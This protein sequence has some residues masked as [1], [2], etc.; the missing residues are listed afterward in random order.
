M[1]GLTA[2]ALIRQMP[3]RGT[4]PILALTA[5]AFE[6]DRTA[7]QQAGL[8]E[9]LAKPIEPAALFGAL[10]RW[11]QPRGEADGSAPAAAESPA[12]PFPTEPP[13]SVPAASDGRDLLS[14]IDGLDAN[15]GLEYLG[16]QMEVYVRVLKLFAERCEGDIAALRAALDAGEFQDARRMAHTI[17]GNAAVLGATELQPLA[18]EL[19][20]LIKDDE[21]L[22]RLLALT[23][24]VAAVYGALAARLRAKLMPSRGPSQ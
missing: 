13:A 5:N 4:V 19:E 9:H 10:L 11:L 22:P 3:G 20:M 14:E 12:S 24:R 2:A 23:N 21:E 17:K 18:A 16:D 1:D 6:E 8:N 7:S 15:R